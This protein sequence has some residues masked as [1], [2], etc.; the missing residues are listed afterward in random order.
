MSKYSK[1]TTLGKAVVAT[2]YIALCVLYFS[3]VNAPA[4][5]AYPVGW[6]A[7]ATLCGGGTPLLILALVCSA[8]GDIFGTTGQLLPQIGA[9]A[10]AQICYLAMMARGS[11]LKTTPTRKLIAAALIPLTLLVVALTVIIPKAAGVAFL[12]VA[13]TLYA[14]L[15]GTMVFFAG[16]SDSWTVKM[17]ALLF[18]LSDFMLAISLFATPISATIYLPPYF[19]GQIL[20][21]WGLVNRGQKGCCKMQK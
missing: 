3:A 2:I 12:V 15:I 16:L 6:L 18:M 11:N 9:F 20:L 19:L 5:L 7:V 8:L 1:H 4:K 17:G 21:W 13:T 10:V 14:L